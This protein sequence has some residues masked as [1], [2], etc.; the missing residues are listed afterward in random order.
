ML[1]S[2]HTSVGGPGGTIENVLIAVSLPMAGKLPRVGIATI[3]W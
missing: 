2:V 3:D 1:A